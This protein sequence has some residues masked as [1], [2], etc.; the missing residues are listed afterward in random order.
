MTLYDGGQQTNFFLVVCNFS[1][2]QKCN[3]DRGEE[4]FFITYLEAATQTYSSSRVEFKTV[5]LFLQIGL[6]F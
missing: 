5:L 3:Y 1:N 2:N 4:E 6:H